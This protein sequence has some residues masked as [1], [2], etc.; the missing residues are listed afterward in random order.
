[1][2]DKTVLTAPE[3]GVHYCIYPLLARWYM[4]FSGY[5]FWKRYGGMMCGA[6]IDESLQSTSMSWR[7]LRSPVWNGALCV[8]SSLMKRF[9][10]PR[11]AG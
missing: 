5:R 1:L 10:Q 3:W 7:M 4:R 6:L 8:G 9:L 11:L 2:M